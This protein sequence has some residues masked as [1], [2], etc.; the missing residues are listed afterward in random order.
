MKSRILYHLLFSGLIS[1]SITS[2]AIAQMASLPENPAYYTTEQAER[3]EE[4][5]QQY[6]VICH[7]ENLNDGEF[8][9]PLKGTSFSIRWV[10]VSMN[11]LFEETLEMP[12]GQANRFSGQ[13]Y[14]D[15]IAF[16]LQENDIPAGDES[17]PSNLTELAALFLPGN[18]LN[19]GQAVRRSGGPAGGFAP[20]VEIPEWETEPS[21][22]A[23]ISNVTESLL[24]NPPAESWLT[25]RGTHNATGYSPLDEINKNNVDDLRVAWSL[26]LPAGPNESTPLIH[27]G[28]MFVHSYGDNIMAL[29]CSYRR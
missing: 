17:L 19:S 8:G 27:E 16:I 6:C 5:Y 26:A 22:L 23:S 21:P 15:M 11:A 7:G 3:G 20:G 12:P 28:V 9:A 1:I 24:A 25:W 14:A 10:G 4:L 2:S 29:K 13:Q 18:S